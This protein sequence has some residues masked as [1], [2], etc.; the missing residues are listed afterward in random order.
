[1]RSLFERL[2]SESA[3]VLVIRIGLG[4]VLLAVGSWS[5]VVAR[6]GASPYGAQPENLANCTFCVV[7]STDSKYHH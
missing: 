3:G 6:G 1:M 2:M 5:V 7:S 4:P